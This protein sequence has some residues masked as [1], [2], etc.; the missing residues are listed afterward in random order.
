MNREQRRKN[1]E[2]LNPR[3]VPRTQMDVDK[4][5]AEGVEAWVQGAMKIAI[6]ILLDKHDMEVETVQRIDMEMENAAR[7]LLNNT[8]SWSFVNKVLKENGI[9]EVRFT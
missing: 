1:K 7:N 2:K 6:Y 3:R 9:R 8:L 5:Y 4:A